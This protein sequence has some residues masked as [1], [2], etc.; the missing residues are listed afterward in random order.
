METQDRDYFLDRVRAEREMALLTRDPAARRAHISLAE[1][2]IM[3]VLAMDAKHSPA[4]DGLGES[5]AAS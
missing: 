2:Y 4:P 1:A 3:R 5:D